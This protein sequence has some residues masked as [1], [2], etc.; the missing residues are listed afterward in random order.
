MK[1]YALSAG[2]PVLQPENLKNEVFLSELKRLQADI[3]VVVA[4]RMLPEVVWSMP[5]M[6]TFNLHASLLPQYRGAAPINWAL[7]NGEK[8]TGVTTFFLK[9]E[10]DTGEI[11]FQEK[12]PIGENDNA[13]TLHDHLMMLGARREPQYQAQLA[14]LQVVSLLLLAV[15]MGFWIAGDTISGAAIRT[16]L[17][18]GTTGWTLAMGEIVLWIALMV[19][20]VR[21]L[22][23]RGSVAYITVHTLLTLFLTWSLRW[24][25]LMQV[26][27]LPKYNVMLNPYSLPMGTD[28]IQAIIGTIG[29]WIAL[30][31]IFR[32]GI[33]WVNNKVQ[34][35]QKVAQDGGVQHG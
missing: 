15:C 7:I 16:Q 9:H 1:E 14:R 11:I 8:E 20:A 10:I 19:L 6:G 29:L 12:V 35:Q 23:R 3:Q 22:T 28:G 24:L 27:T 30:V 18:F 25:L 2:L 33:R 26:Q 17:R 4:F 13:E 21:L 5:P 34:N 32:E 31:I